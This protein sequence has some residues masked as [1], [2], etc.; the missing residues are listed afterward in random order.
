VL[1]A[2]ILGTYPGMVLLKDAPSRDIASQ[3]TAGQ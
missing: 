2:E 3:C 1:P